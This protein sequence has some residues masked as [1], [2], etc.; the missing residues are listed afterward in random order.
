[1]ANM[2]KI[3]ASG[4]NCEQTYRLF[5]QLFLEYADHYV[6]EEHIQRLKYLETHFRERERRLKKG[7]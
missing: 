2:D 1:M 5:G 4:L 3:P 7:L 6:D